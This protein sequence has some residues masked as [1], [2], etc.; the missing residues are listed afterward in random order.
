MEFPAKGDNRMEFPIGEWMV[1]EGNKM[2]ALPAVGIT[3]EEVVIISYN[4]F[5]RT[6]AKLPETVKENVFWNRLKRRLHTCFDVRLVSK[7]WAFKDFLELEEQNEVCRLQILRMR[8]MMKNYH[9]TFSKKVAY[10]DESRLFMNCFISIAEVFKPYINTYYF[11]HC[12]C[13]VHLYQH[14]M[15]LCLRF[16]QIVTKFD[17]SALVQSSLASVGTLIPINWSQCAALI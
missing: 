10:A 9:L 1:E 6:I 5:L 11:T 8:W 4:R 12:F 3:A 7:V 14:G 15:N 2:S 16:L 17:V 13:S